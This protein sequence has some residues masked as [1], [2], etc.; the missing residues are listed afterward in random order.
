MLLCIQGIDV[1]W[2]VLLDGSVPSPMPAMPSTPLRRLVSVDQATGAGKPGL[3]IRPLGARCRAPNPCK[4]GVAPFL[5][6][7]T[8]TKNGPGLLPLRPGR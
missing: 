7:Q 1:Q 8:Q 3:P 5:P 6:F 4:R 2:V